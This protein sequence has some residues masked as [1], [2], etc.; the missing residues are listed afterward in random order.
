MLHSSTRIAT[1]LR[2]KREKEI[3][4]SIKLQQ[5]MRR[6]GIKCKRFLNNFY[7]D[8]FG[9]KRWKKLLFWSPRKDEE[10]R[11]KCQCHV[12]L[13]N[14]SMELGN[15]QTMEKI[16]FGCWQEG[17]NLHHLTFPSKC[18]ATGGNFTSELDFTRQD[19]L[20]YRACHLMEVI[21]SMIVV[22]RLDNSSRALANQL[23]QSLFSLV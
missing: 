4:N 17:R 14:F 21:K 9:P 23:L 2:K 22:N 18:P 13:W 11:R 6:S 3:Y 12:K 5:K 7:F 10:D 19:W 8:L 20:R 1:G 15:L 16:C